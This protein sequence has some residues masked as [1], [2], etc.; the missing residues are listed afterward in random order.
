MD[1]VRVHYNSSKP[2]QLQ[3]LA[4]TQGTEIH[5][6]P[7]QER[8]LPHEAWHVVQQ[9]QGRVMPTMQAK[10]V[11]INDDGG[12]EREADLMGKKATQMKC[13]ECE[14]K[15]ELEDE[16]QAKS[17]NLRITQFAKGDPCYCPGNKYGPYYQLPEYNN[18]VGPGE[19]F[20]VTQVNDIYKANAAKSHSGTLTTKITS[21]YESDSD[22]GALVR[23]SD[24]NHLV[25]EVDHIVPQ[26][27]GGCNS[28]KNAQVISSMENGSKG[29]TYPYGGYSG[30]S[31]FN[32]KTNKWT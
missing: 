5:V 29:E 31:T 26:T 24:V 25:A 16:L 28:V 10:G 13:A 7:G 11:V 2:A 27:L 3:A 30:Q 15:T 19:D 8:H 23:F 14:K 17:R 22:G 20:T 4:Y 32:P 12:L 6:G 9:K 1:D 18:Q 21:L